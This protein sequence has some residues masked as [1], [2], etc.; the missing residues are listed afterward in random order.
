MRKYDE[1]VEAVADAIEEQLTAEDGWEVG[2]P[3]LK[4]MCQDFARA[5]IRVIAPAVLDE[6]ANVVIGYIHPD[7]PRQP[8]AAFASTQVRAL[9]QRYET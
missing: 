9:K 7:Y 5:A 3:Q 2:T 8:G 6:A 4:R 1:L